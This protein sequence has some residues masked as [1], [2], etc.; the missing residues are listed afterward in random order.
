MKACQSAEDLGP[1][2]IKFPKKAIPRW[3]EKLDGIEMPQNGHKGELAHA[4]MAAKQ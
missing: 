3:P 1:H 4:R 2:D